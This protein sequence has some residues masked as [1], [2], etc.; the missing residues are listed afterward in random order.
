MRRLNLQVVASLD[1]DFR[2][3]GYETLP[4]EMK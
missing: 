4:D 2:Q 3:E 1:E